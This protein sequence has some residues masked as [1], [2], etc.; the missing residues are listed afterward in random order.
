M[1]DVGR[2]STYSEDMITQ[3]QAYLALCEDE[4]I[5]KG[6]DE[7]PVYSLKV[8][9]PTIE[10]LARH[11][12]VNRDTLYAWA[13]VH[14]E[15]SDILEDI[16]AEQ[17][18]KLINNGLSGDYNPTITKLMLTK[19]GYSDKIDTDLT[20]GGNAIAGFN[21]IKNGDNNTDNTPNA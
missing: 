18:D 5:E 17:A 16:R 15:F 13:K 1:A 4:E 10:G 8:K 19:H 20:S 3:S 6:S 12:K 9:L 2:P 14:A 11:L 21:F 7:R